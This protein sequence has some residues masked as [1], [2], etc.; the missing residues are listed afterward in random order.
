MKPMAE[1]MAE[2][3]APISPELFEFED[4]SHLHAGHAGAREGG[5]FAVIIVS[6]AFNGQNRVQRQ[7]TVQTL[8]APLFAAKLIHALSI[9]AHTPQEFF[10]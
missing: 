5:H 9:K 3:L 4:Q 7:R 1:Q 6:S 8:F 2:L 10:H